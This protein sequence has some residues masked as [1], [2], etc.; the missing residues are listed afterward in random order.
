VV[1]GLVRDSAGN[2]VTGATILAYPADRTLWSMTSLS[3]PRIGT[4]V[5]DNTGTYRLATLPAGD[6]LIVAFDADSSPGLVGP[7][8]FE[9]AERLAARRT[10]TW[11]QTM[12]VDLVLADL[13]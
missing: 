13:K 10:L 3:P 7:E 9:T 12:T 4:T 5:A 11:S 1:T 2:G 6:Y 8:L